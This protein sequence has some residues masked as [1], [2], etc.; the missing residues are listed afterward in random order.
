VNVLGVTVDGDRVVHG[1]LGAHRRGV[2][3]RGSGPLAVMVDKGGV[4]VASRTRRQG[5]INGSQG[6][7][8]PATMV[9]E[10]GVG[11]VGRAC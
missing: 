11:E 4:S 7:G 8:L 3:S 6:S 10:G 1:R 5:Q 2:R 9:E